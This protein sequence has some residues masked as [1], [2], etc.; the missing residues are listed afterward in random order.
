MN[1]ERREGLFSILFC[2]RAAGHSG[3]NKF[4]NGRKKSGIKSKVEAASL[5]ALWF[6]GVSWFFTGRAILKTCG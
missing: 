2:F 1:S 4:S 5:T 3:K 6:C